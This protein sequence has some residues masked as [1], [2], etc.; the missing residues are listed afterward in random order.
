MLRRP[1]RAR[2][3]KP[4]AADDDGGGASG[5]GGGGAGC[6]RARGAAGELIKKG[7]LDWDVR[8]GLC[9]LCVPCDARV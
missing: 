7:A 6:A 5:G 1:P 2:P 3:S 8:L 9:V 4:A